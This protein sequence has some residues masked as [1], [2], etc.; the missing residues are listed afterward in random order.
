MCGSRLEKLF[1]DLL[2]LRDAGGPADEHHFVDLR[3]I[4]PRVGERLLGRPNGLLQQLVD[5]LLEL[6]ARQLHLEVLGTGLIRR[7]ERQVDVGFH[8]GGQ[9]HLRFLRRFAEPLQRHAILAEIDAVAL[10]ELAGD[11]VHDR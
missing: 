5:Q 10:L 2:H 7:D 9:L 8:H 1:H 11:P 3:R 6:G 4:E